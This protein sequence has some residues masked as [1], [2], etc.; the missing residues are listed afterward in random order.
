M[1]ECMNEHVVRI[2]IIEWDALNISRVKG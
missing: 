2:Q 1:N